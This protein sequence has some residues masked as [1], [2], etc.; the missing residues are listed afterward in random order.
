[1]GP[2][3]WS[4]LL[5]PW[6]VY[7]CCK[8]QTQ[9]TYG[10]EADPLT[11]LLICHRC[12]QHTRHKFSYYSQVRVGHRKDWLPSPDRFFTITRDWLGLP[13]LERRRKQ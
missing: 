4:V 1:M 13:E 5:E 8:C 2:E 12:C 10:N 11:A 6:A 9:R 7:E 3:E